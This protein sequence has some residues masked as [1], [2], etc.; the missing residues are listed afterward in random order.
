MTKI[1]LF[2]HQD[3]GKKG[4]IFLKILQ[5]KLNDIKIDIYPNIESF[6]KKC[7]QHNLYFEKEI[8]VLFAD[9]EDRLK[10]LYE[11]KDIFQDK[12]IVFVLPDMHQ[13]NLSFVHKFFPRYFTF[14]DDKYDDLCDVLNKMA[15]R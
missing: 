5:K 7:K 2:L 11:K 13:E 10:Q 8:I 12:K 4:Q 3:S 14:I 1:S 6:Q 15:I 9:N